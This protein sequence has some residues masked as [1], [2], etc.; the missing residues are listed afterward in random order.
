MIATTSP[1]GDSRSNSITTPSAPLRRGRPKL[2]ADQAARA[3]AYR[4]RLKLRRACTTKAK[5]AAAWDQLPKAEKAFVE[6]CVQ[7]TQA[8]Q[9][10]RLNDDFEEILRLQGM[11][12]YTQQ[13]ERQRVREERAAASGKLDSPNRGVIL[14]DAPHGCGWLVSGGVDLEKVH[15]RNQKDG[16]RVA[17]RGHGNGLEDQ[18][19]APESEST[20]MNRQNFAWDAV[21]KEGPSGPGVGW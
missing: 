1:K 2:H 12:E 18:V 13:I 3:R 20:F 19:W 6:E 7:L 4:R 17:P 21:G 8:L 5:A 16:R 15:S 10:A 9:T 11:L 14:H